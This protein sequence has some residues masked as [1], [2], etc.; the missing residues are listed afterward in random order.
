MRSKT[1]IQNKWRSRRGWLYSA[2]YTGKA[3]ILTVFFLFLSFCIQPIHQAMA[4]ES[5]T[6]EEAAAAVLPE[7]VA[8]QLPDAS[9]VS[10]PEEKQADDE[11]NE[12]SVLNDSAETV[13]QSLETDSVTTNDEA[14]STDDDTETNAQ[15]ALGE[16]GGTEQ[17][18]V[19]TADTADET[20]S[21]NQTSELSTSPDQGGADSAVADDAVGEEGTE[22]ISTPTTPGES[23]DEAT[24]ETVVDDAM[25]EDDGL[26]GETLDTETENETNETASSAGGSDAGSGDDEPVADAAASDTEADE[27]AD[28]AADA[29][30]NTEAESNQAFSGSSG[31]GGGS[32]TSAESATNDTEDLIDNEVI[33]AGVNDLVGNV[34]NEVV[35]LTRQL[36][37]EENYYQFS[38][39][40][41]VAVGDGTFHCTTKD[42]ISLDPDAAIYAEQDAEGDMEIYLRTSKGDIKQLT[43]NSYDD[44]SPA[45]DFAS[46]RAVWQRLIDGRYQIIS[47]DLE[48]R[49]ESQLTFSRTNSMEPK[50]SKEGIVWQAW[51]GNDWE[52]MFFD[53]TYTDQITNNDAQD[54]TPVI[55]DGY[56]LWSILGGEKQEARVYSLE[57]G[58]MMTITGHEGGAVANPRF[59]LVYDTKFDNGDVVTL[60]FDP[61]TGLAQPVSAQPA[62]LPFDIPEPDPVGEIR[63]LIQN[64][65]NQKDKEVV[66]EL[67]T[68][69]DKDLNLAGA[70]GTTS[71][72]L[73]LDTEIDLEDEEAATTTPPA[74]A[75]E[76]TEFDLVI[77]KEASS[78]QSV[79]NRPF[80][81][82]PTTTMPHAGTQE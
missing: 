16:G 31:S 58:E 14:S 20:G 24:D 30:A 54:V 74:P 65:S 82:G 81:D 46:M 70:T 26:S 15:P 61:V 79:I 39:Q 22:E 11:P 60:G 2:V 49:T 55:E 35:N 50:V 21:T 12:Q 33:E 28:T 44:S 34:V 38:K 5:T 77:T 72:T 56:V 29:G 78:T 76:L 66:T 45:V 80:Y 8:A 48:T 13:V 7:E 67:I 52:I 62:E 25:S 32:G 10:I 18:E 1:L 43:D 63:A 17:S 4:N 69:T 75:L 9:P 41:C 40:S 6:T 59:V 64:K 47:Y 71:D 36:V 37:T 27:V 68:D 23:I 57:T 3:S 19:E 42:P 73:V 51:D 53:G